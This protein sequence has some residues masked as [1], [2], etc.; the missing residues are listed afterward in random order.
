MRNVR[1]EREIRGICE[2]HSKTEE[3]FCLE[4]KVYCCPNCAPTHPTH[5]LLPLPEAR[6]VLYNPL[7]HLS[8]L[9]KA[10]LKSLSVRKSGLQKKLALARSLE[11]KAVQ[12]VELTYEALAVKVGNMQKSAWARIG[13]HFSAAYRAIRDK[14]EAVKQVYERLKACLRLEDDLLFYSKVAHRV[15]MEEE[16]GTFSVPISLEFAHLEE[17][18]DFLGNS[19]V[20]SKLELE[21]SALPKLLYLSRGSGNYLIYS[22]ET[23]RIE[24]KQLNSKDII[25]PELSRYVVLPY[26]SVF[27]TGGNDWKSSRATDLAF[28]FFPENGQVTV[29]KSMRNRRAS[30]ICLYAEN[31][32]FALSGNPEGRKISLD[33]ETYSMET[34]L[35]TDIA[36]INI[37]RI[38]ASATYCHGKIYVFGGH[39]E[40]EDS[41]ETYSIDTNVWEI[42]PTKL[43]IRLWLHS[44]SLI[45]SSQVLIFGGEYPIEMV[46][47]HAVIYDLETMTFSQTAQ[48]PIDT[49]WQ[50]YWLHVAYAGK[51]LYT[52]NE[53]GRV[54]KYTIHSRKWS[55]F[56]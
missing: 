50:S 44:S 42:L 34:G 48:M 11:N 54:L 49:E 16:K 37:G 46:N 41:I 6:R 45:S 55:S 5:T 30:H 23:D 2:R 28:M 40:A 7:T 33:C 38:Y 15:E 47:R 13:V 10:Y 29:V 17:I 35:W 32:I 1:K 18:G 27:V 39:C 53:K 26:Q 25:V 56:K 14:E 21:R 36:P 4:D 52:M 20:V 9:N 43:P 8:D 51:A 3:L 19:Y 22:F 31:A 12:E 24:A